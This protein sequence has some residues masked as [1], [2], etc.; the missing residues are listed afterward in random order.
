MQI[1]MLKSPKEYAEDLIEL[2]FT[3]DDNQYV[4]KKLKEY[5]CG[6]DY[7]TDV[8]FTLACQAGGDSA[9][10]IEDRERR[11]EMAAVI[12]NLKDHVA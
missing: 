7:I 3:F 11:K 9:I 4:S 1:Q 6:K 8:L 5:K 2:G 10:R 12:S